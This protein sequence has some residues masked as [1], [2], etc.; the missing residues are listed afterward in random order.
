VPGARF[1]VE[2]DDGR[3]LEGWASDGHETA[4]VFFHLG[5][6]SAAIPF[7][8]CVDASLRRGLRFVTYARPGYGGSTR[9][10]G[11]SVARCTD[12]VAA[13][14]RALDLERLHVVGWSGGGPHAL[15]CAALLPGLVAS[16][17]TIAGVAPWGAEA[18]DWMDGMAAENHA[19]FG[20]ALEGSDALVSFLRDAAET[21]GDATAETVA[22]ELGGLVT[23]VDREALRG[24]MAGYL[25]A[26]LRGAVATGIWGWHD[27]DLAFT[28]D[29]GFGLADIAVPVAVWQGREDAMV[30]YAHGRWLAERV[31]DA[32]AHLFDDEGHLS[33]L[34]RFD[35][36]LDGLLASA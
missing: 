20:A 7:E 12:D 23:D 33:L 3:R 16:A 19:E 26:L 34:L 14:A 28:R 31:P 25:A 18:L 10:E 4:A 24:A 6:P 36:I 30:P 11:R 9:D 35:E 5:T 2:L 32:A 8:P 29:W 1:E 17:A 15:A 13:I 22:A 27:D 21:M